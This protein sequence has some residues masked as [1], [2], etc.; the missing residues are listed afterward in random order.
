MFHKATKSLAKQLDPEGDLIPVYCLLD[1]K[2]FRPLCLVQ[3]KSKNPWWQKGRYHKT[4]Y[5]L[6]DVLFPG[7]Q[8]AQLGFLSP[9]IY[10]SDPITIVDNV[11]GKLEGDVSVT[12]DL[13]TLELKSSA[14]MS[15]ARSVKVKKR[16]ISSHVL[17]SLNGDSKISLD[18]QLIKQS[19]KFRRDLYVVTETVETVEEAEFRENSKTEGSILA[20]LRL[21]TKMTGLRDSKK[22][23][24][25]PKDCIL[26][27]RVK[28]LI[29]RGESLG[30]SIFPEDPRL[31][32]QSCKGGYLADGA[33][34]QIT[35][36]GHMEIT[37]GGKP[38]LVVKSKREHPLKEVEQECAPLRLLS[39]DLHVKFLNGFLAVVRNNDL[40]QE[41]ELQLEQ[42]LDGINPIKLKTHRPELQGLVEN[43]QDSTGA[44]CPAIGEAVLY[45]L[46]ALD[47]L[48]ESELLLLE[49][50]VERKMV[51]KQ[52]PLVHRILE[53]DFS[54]KK[55]TL[56]IDTQKEFAFIEDE[57]DIMEAMIKLSGV[58]VQRNGASL[59]MTGNPDAFLTLGAL[60]VVLYVLNL[61]SS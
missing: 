17:D 18:H 47:E 8:S 33:T 25:V 37:R 46:Q 20:E 22:A 3:R 31:T 30:I 6:L 7:N 42:A 36:S 38:H 44:V 16:H 35:E 49:E 54:N 14:S 41:L 50:S 34:Q 60:Y 40:L 4:D 19:E 52:V 56:T 2:H 53:N 11:D 13:A 27:F 29:I 10:D 39:T 12:T 59:A 21:R 58:T 28:R 43:V 32:F 9:D 45:F 5:K 24:I 23:V 55:G 15:H 26:A 57:L 61:L 48:S 51:P 1:Q